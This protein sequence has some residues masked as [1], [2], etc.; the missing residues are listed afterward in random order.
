LISISNRGTAI[1][2]AHTYAVPHWNW[3]QW[4]SQICARLTMRALQI[5][6]LFVLRNRSCMYVKSV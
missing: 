2:R 6:L 5:F 3:H 1:S 4:M